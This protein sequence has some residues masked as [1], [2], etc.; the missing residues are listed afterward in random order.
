MEREQMARREQV[1]PTE[2]WAELELRLEW[3]EQVNYELIRPPLLFRL[4][5]A[6]RSRQTGAS[7]SRL[8]RRITGFK[9]Y[10]MRSLFE[11]EEVEGH[12]QLDPEVRGLVLSLKA[13]Y[14]PMR[15]NEIGT[16]CY[17][18]TGQRPHH[19][20][21]KKVLEGQP[22][23]IRMFGRF[24]PYPEIEDATERRLAIVTL[25]A[26]GWTVKSI[27]GYLK[28]SRPTVYRTLGKWFAEGVLGLKDK[29]RGGV[30]KTDLRAMN[31]VRKLQE[32]PELGAFRISAALEQMGI[33][34][35]PRTCGRILAVNRQLYGLEKPKRGPKEKKEMPFASD[36]RHEI[37]TVD[38]RYIGHNIS[39]ENKL[40]CISVLENHSRALLASS[41]SRS[42]DLTAYLSV[43]YSAVS[44]YGAPEV[45]VTDS[46]G[47]FRANQ[48]KAIYGSLGITK[49]EIEKGQPWQSYIESAFSVQQRL[50]DYHFQKAQ[51]F[52]EIVAAHDQFVADYDTQK[53]FA[54]EERKD[55]RR[56]PA[57]VLG[58]LVSV[59]HVPEE[60]ERAFFSV[61]FTRTLDASGYARIRH[62]RVYCEEGLAHSQGALW[63]GADA[64]TAEFAGE[65]LARY[66]VAY[67]P[68]A[69]RLREVKS[70]RLYTTRYHYSAQLRLFGLAEFLGEAGW[71]KAVRLR[72]YAPRGS[73]KHPALQQALF[74]YAEAL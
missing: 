9:S 46:E 21:I 7:E 45:L 26:E 44:H 37:W 27:A 56:S 69:G 35:S 42:K 65:T 70:P 71:L 39:E 68:S 58:W 16:I 8:R 29:P 33:Y 17:V 18:R 6:E 52:E 66:E 50:A 74:A 20:T 55:G 32:N 40:Y 19:R 4:S 62:W 13:E 15:P 30:W 38:I 63:L 43:L 24:K 64:L 22:T 72:G 31:E 23:A 12:S 61:R 5:V 1:E 36:K 49:K 51:S 28:T 67:S 59:R 73:R 25:H 60:L 11:P 10:G 54:H 57:E 41:V 2:G 3:P 34:L 53:H 14:P 47:L 48:A